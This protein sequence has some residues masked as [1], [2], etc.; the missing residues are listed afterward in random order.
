MLSAYTHGIFFSPPDARNH[1]PRGHIIY[2]FSVQ[3]TNFDEGWQASQKE[4]GERRPPAVF[5]R[6]ARSSPPPVMVFNH[7]K[8]IEPFSGQLQ[9]SSIRYA[10]CVAVQGSEV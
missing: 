9:G 1:N 5:V 10:R 3:E 4:E 7:D 8:Q 2:F 6:F